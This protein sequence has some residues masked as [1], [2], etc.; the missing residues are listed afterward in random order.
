MAIKRF[1]T[2]QTTV[3]CGCLYS[4]YPSVPTLHLQCH[5]VKHVPRP[6]AGLLSVLV[7]FIGTVF[8]IVCLLSFKTRQVWQ[9]IW[10]LQF[11]SNSLVLT[12][13]YLSILFNNVVGGLSLNVVDKAART[14]PLGAMC[15]YTSLL[16]LTLTTVI[17]VTLQGQSTPLKRI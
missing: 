2:S 13:L 7:Y 12:G 5:P 10:M 11:I 14:V 17:A 6:P 15:C 3:H 8:Y 4:T 16:W 9:L 1:E